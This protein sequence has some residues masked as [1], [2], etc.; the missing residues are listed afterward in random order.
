MTLTAEIDATFDGGNIRRLHSDSDEV[1]RLAIEP[2]AGDQFF[3]WFF[4][5]LTAPRN[6]RYVVRIEN[7]GDSS[8]PRGWEN[9]RVVVSNDYQNWSRIETSYIDGVLQFHINTVCEITFVAYF[10]PYTLHQHQQ[11]IARCAAH[12]HVTT[13]VAGRTVQGRSV[14]CLVVGDP[15]K[16][17]KLWTIARQHPGETMAEWWM[18]GYLNRLCDNDDA[19]VREILRRAVFYVVPNMNPD[20]SYHG[21]L[22]TNAAGKNLN[23]EWTNP[24][25]EDSPEVFFVRK[26][27]LQ[28]GVSF[29]LD[30][31]GDEALAYNFVAGTEGTDSWS[32]SRSMLQDS[33]KQCL[34][35][36]N[37][38][39]QSEVGYPITPAGRANYDICS[40]YVAEEF[41]CLA[42]TLEM[43]FK[44]TEQTPNHEE[45]WS[46][47]RSEKLG[48]SCV[49]AIYHI[50]DRLTPAN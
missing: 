46:A 49:D 13:I 20:G 50:L 28:H 24:S 32:D 12:E 31:H 5:R 1:I 17:L 27:M 33:F 9:Y 14:D 39:F 38:D 34:Q 6:R 30:V 7:A 16:P 29:C 36:A 45:G 21:Y 40:N 4:F 43:P 22:R 18:Q 19:V 37:P 42:L 48:E 15:A 35:A 11:L 25:E 8:Y 26:M 23:R 41:K 47:G 44:D 10:A 3:Q 2:D